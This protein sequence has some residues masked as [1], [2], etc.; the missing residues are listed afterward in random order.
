MTEKTRHTLFALAKEKGFQLLFELPGD[1]ADVTVLME[2]GEV[3]EDRTKEVGPV[4][5]GAVE[6]VEA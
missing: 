6:Q 2:D 3:K 5:N 1:S 4:T